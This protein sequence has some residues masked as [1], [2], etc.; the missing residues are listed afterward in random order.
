MKDEYAIVLDFLEN[1]HPGGKPQPLAQVIGEQHFN[2]LEV[3]IRDDVHPIVG[4]R[5]YIGD[6]DREKVKY[7]IGK[8]SQD[9]LT[10]NA[11]S[12]ISYVLKKLVDKNKDKF[13]NFFNEATPLTPRMHSL[14]LLPGIGK[15]HM[16]EIIEEREKEDF[17][18]FEELKERVKLL[19]DPEKML[20]KRLDKELEGDVKH[21]L[22]I[23]PPQEKKGR[24]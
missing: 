16:W 5:I 3:A 20:A 21:Y 8:I 1:G 17:E 2:L 11:K 9:K 23:S 15:K 12:E 14:E 10:A 18:S 7:V 13:V 6:G 19:P 24:G 4:D 22:F